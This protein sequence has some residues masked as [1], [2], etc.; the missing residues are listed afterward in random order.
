M[1]TPI[2]SHRSA[3]GST[4]RTPLGTYVGASIA[5]VAMLLVGALALTAIGSMIGSPSNPDCPPDGCYQPWAVPL[6][7][8]FQ[9]VIFAAAGLYTYASV[10]TRDT[11]RLTTVLL[12]IATV[13]LIG[14]V[15][16]VLGS[17]TD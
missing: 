11:A 8:V 17:L 7:T 14:T 5:W 10:R 13:Q 12:I 1:T 2:L 15:V 3:M 9:G 16:L 6:S 4:D